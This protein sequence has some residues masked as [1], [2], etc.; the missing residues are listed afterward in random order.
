MYK[1]ENEARRLMRRV[2]TLVRENADL[3]T[4]SKKMAAC[5]PPAL[6]SARPSFLDAF[7][8]AGD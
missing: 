3:I 4:A 8:P 7:F 1:A 2:E 6:D 5:G